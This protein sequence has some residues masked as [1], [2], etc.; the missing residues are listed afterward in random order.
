MC[1]NR[2]FHQSFLSRARGRSPSIEGW[3]KMPATNPRVMTQTHPPSARKAR[4]P[5]ARPIDRPSRWR[6]RPHTRARRFPK[7]SRTTR[8][9]THASPPPRRSLRAR[10]HVHDGDDDDAANPLAREPGGGDPRSGIRPR[11][12]ARDAMRGHRADARHQH[13]NFRKGN[14]RRRR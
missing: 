2:E 12:V 7:S 13:E 6:A 10:H 9:S 3:D 8:I 11:G 5:I 1:N 4:N 14:R